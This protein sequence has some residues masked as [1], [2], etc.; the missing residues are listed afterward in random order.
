M[1]GLTDQ[2][3]D[4]TSKGI[5]GYKQDWQKDIM[6]RNAYGTESQVTITQLRGIR[7]FN[8]CFQSQLIHRWYL[9]YLYNGLFRK[10]DQ[11]IHI[12]SLEVF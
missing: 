10:N 4:S 3:S 5:K 1:G 12:W 8:K 9:L 11:E 7:N 6:G 2:G